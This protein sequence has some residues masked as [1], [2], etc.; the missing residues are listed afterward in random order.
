MSSDAERAGGRAS[1]SSVRVC[2]RASA[3]GE[4]AGAGAGGETTLAAASFLLCFHRWTAL[5]DGRYLGA[6]DELGVVE[7]GTGDNAAAADGE[8]RSC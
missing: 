6:D 7:E 1:H 2:A 4:G 5:D 3:R 8:A